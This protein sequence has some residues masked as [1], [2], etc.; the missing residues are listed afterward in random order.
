MR[1]S[2]RK[3]LVRLYIT[4]LQ[5]TILAFQH[6]KNRLIALRC[7][8][9]PSFHVR[10]IKLVFHVARMMKNPQISQDKKIVSAK[11]VGVNLDE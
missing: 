10:S 1:F 6:R 5:A 7:W 4:L 11:L 3:T 8:I 2:K 9:L